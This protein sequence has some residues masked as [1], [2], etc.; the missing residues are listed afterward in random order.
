MTTEKEKKRCLHTIDNKT[1]KKLYNR[2]SSLSR[3]IW[4]I[5]YC[6]RFINQCQKEKIEKC[7][8]TENKLESSLKK[9]IRLVQQRAFLEEIKVLNS[10]KKIEKKQ[11]IG[12][13]H[14]FLNQNRILRVGGRLQHS[15]LSYREKHSIILSYENYLSKLIVLNAHETLHGENQ[16]ALAFVRRKFWIINAKKA[17][18][19]LINKCIKCIR[20]KEQTP[21]QQMGQLPVPK[22]TPASLFQHTGIDY[23][24]PT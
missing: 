21:Q 1:N 23:A 18:K 20:Y 7:S 24:G 5:A 9:I 17:V 15:H 10:A 3:T 19:V 13:L 14:P 8:L 12:N 2:F 16:L 6:S 11:K 4:V 22:V